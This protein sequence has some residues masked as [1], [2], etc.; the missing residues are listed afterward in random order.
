MLRLPAGILI[1]LMYLWCILTGQ[2]SAQ[3]AGGTNQVHFRVDHISV[4][5]GLTQGSVYYML[6]DSRGFLWLGTQDGLN[7]YDGHRFRTYR[8]A[9]DERGTPL[10]GTLRGVNIFGIIEAPNGDLWV[11]TEAGLNRY[12]RRCD[13]FEFMNLPGKQLIASR[14]LP[15]FVD[16]TSLLYLSD[17]EGLVHFD[18]Q[19]RQRT[20]LDP[21]LHPTK[22]YDLQSST[23]RTPEGDIWLHEPKGLLRY[24]LRTRSYTRYFSDRPGNKLG[25]VQA[26]FSFLIDKDSVAWVGT[27]QGLIRLDYRH[28]TFQ[29]Y[30]TAGAKPISAIYSIS[31]DQ[32]GRLWLGTQRDGV[33]YFDKR[34]RLFGRVNGSLDNARPLTDFKITKLY[35]DD[36]GIVWANVDPD[37]LA[38]IVPDAFQFNGM[39]KRLAVPTL[40]PDQTLSNYTIRGFLEERFDRLWIATENGIDV[41][42]P[43]TNRIVQRYLTNI[44]RNDLPVNTFVKCL[45]RDPQRRIW[46]GTTGGVMLYKPQTQTFDPIRFEPTTSLVAGNYARNLVSVADS[47]LIAATEDGMYALNTIR[48]RW[49]RVT[50]L[51]GQNI[52]SFWYDAPARQ[53]WIGTYLNGYFCYQLPSA[54]PGAGPVNPLAWRLIRTGLNG[55]TIL[56]IRPGPNNKTLW[57]ASD[58]GLVALKPHTGR[59]QLY[60]EPQG[61]AN[62]FVYGSLT[63]V[64]NH[65]WLSTNRGLSRIDLAT[66]TVKNF[67]PADGIQGY[68]FNGNAFVRAANGDMYFGGVNGFNRFQPDLFRSS[69][70]NPLVHIYS[71]SVN[72]MPLAAYA[73]VDEVNQID[74]THDQNTLSLEFAALDYVSNGRN[75]YQYQLSGYDEKWVSA[76]ERNY[77]RYA[78]LPP[79]DYTFQ[80]KAANRDGHW[81]NHVRKLAIHISPPFWLRWPFVLLMSLLA[82][83]LILGWIRRRENAIRTQQAERLRLAYDIQEQVKK[84]IARDLHDE[85]GT[86]LATIKLYTTQLTQQVGETPGILSL[87]TTIFSLIN[88]TIGDIRNL[89]RKLNPKTLEQHGYLP[90]IEELINRI[91]ASGIV[92]AQLLLDQSTDGS[93]PNLVLANRLPTDVEVMLYRITQELLSNSLKHANA[94]YIALRVHQ[95]QHMVTLVYTDDGN[96]FDY[97]AIQQKGNGLG[98]GSIESRVALLNGKIDWQTQPGKGLSVTIDIP[99]GALPGRRLY[100]ALINLSGMEN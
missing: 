10:P 49:S 43:Q 22:E 64:Q 47:L 31:A 88:D 36:L 87:K 6:K 21:S 2:V 76:G 28:N 42:N 89:L 66:Q 50:H 69:F 75:T 93:R 95:S 92:Q 38:R 37:G 79:G 55:Y 61:L 86:R 72:E 52:F 40:P 44:G 57:L 53:L 82:A 62:S 30:E 80:V 90:A 5:D 68:E 15:F 99:V 70:F 85:I 63:D 11:G 91:N 98:L 34:S 32:R 29:T 58:R 94:R 24:N 48:K 83:L 81:S 45:Y 19:T 27:A 4:D 73:Y 78:N 13:R 9:L 77:V 26:V 33:L 14:T 8:P 18:Y 54:R 100:Q 7:R 84:D 67:T 1:G 65:I 96:G 25:S 16:T 59:F 41:L 60:A 17:R 20:V 23:V 51:A 71:F 3:S 74:L 35:V 97:D 56:H 46:V 39:I 12:D